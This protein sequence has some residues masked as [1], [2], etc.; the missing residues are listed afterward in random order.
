ME[1]T[2]KFKKM[3]SFLKKLLLFKLA[4]F[5]K[6]ILKKYRPDI[7]GVTGSVGKT[8]AKD[9][10][11]TVLAP[12]FSVRRNVKNYNN[13]IGL[14]LTIIGSETGGSSV[15]DW[16]GVFAKAIKL[17][18]WRDKKYPGILVLE[19]G[20]DRVGDMKY[21]TSL[22][23]CK[24]GVVTTVAPVHLEYFKTLEK[25]AREKSVIVTHLRKDG[26][27]ILNGD[28]EYIMAMAGNI[29]AKIM[30]Y[31]F[32]K[33]CDISASEVNISQNS[34]QEV[35]GLNFKLSYNGSTVPV[36]LPNILG[37]HLI[38]AAL[39]AAAAA[40]AYG[41][42][43]L[44]IS[45]ALR[46]FIAPR[47]R[48]NLISGIKGT[49]IIDDTYNA[50]P[51]S[52]EAAINTLGKIK[53]RADKYAVLGDML[54]LGDYT[55]E[56]HRRIG[57]AIWENGIGYLITVGERAKLIAAEALNCGMDSDNIYSFDNSAEAGRFIQGRIKAG[58]FILVKGSQGM[59]MEKATKE[60]MAEPLRAQELL[61]RQDKSWTT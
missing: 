32:G 58:D 38:Y 12:K 28:N 56:G 18:L 51:D 34:E 13:E 4:F 44:E 49:Y 60:I 41:M 33:D 59:R 1:I 26:W 31:G 17:L 27:A 45:E 15:S 3:K 57:R 43:L 2:D 7:I 5:A 6:A 48:M 8:S 37:E 22:A 52:M 61:V 16:L 29:K 39:S 53:T 30:T 14:P 20:V 35:C 42:N 54:E 55:E 11:Y 23:P 21:L 25:I 19:M 24:V 36:L 40:V 10:I 9:A 47:G 46:D 50:G